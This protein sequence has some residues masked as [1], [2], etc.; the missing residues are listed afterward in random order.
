MYICALWTTLS[1]KVLRNIE[2]TLTNFEGL[3]G[4]QCSVY[5]NIIAIS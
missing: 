1:I 2:Q 5:S 3:Q 4:Y